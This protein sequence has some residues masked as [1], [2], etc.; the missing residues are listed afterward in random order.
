MSAQFGRWNFSGRP[1]MAG[2]IERAS[3]ML[4]S[5]GPDGESRYAGPSVDI[6]YRAFHTT[7]ES[8]Q[9]QQPVQVA[10][11]AVLTWDGRLDNREELILQFD[12][13]VTLES[14]DVAIV[15]AAYERWGTKS[16]G[17]LI[18]D[19]ALSVW[20]P[21]EQTLI[22]AKDF[23]GTRR[24]YYLHDEE[25]ILWSS[26]LEPLVLLSGKTFQLEKEYLAGWLSFFPAAHLTPYAGIHAVPPST[27]VSLRAGNQ[28]VTR[29]WEFDPHKQIR[30]ATD[31][32]YEE[33]FRAVFRQSVRRR[34]RSD[35]AILAELSGGMD[36]SSIVC[37]ADKLIDEQI[38]EMPRLDTVSYYDDSEPNWNER[39]YFTLVENQRG[40]PG[41]H[42]DMS[43]QDSRALDH[44]SE[45]FCA[46]P[47]S[48][49]SSQVTQQLAVYM[50][51]HGHRAVLSGIGGDEMTGGIPTAVPELA[52]L[53]ARGRFARLA[54]RLKAWAIHKKQPWFHLLGA[55]LRE[56]FS[57]ELGRRHGRHMPLHWLLPNYARTYRA[58]LCGYRRRLKLFGARPSFQENLQ[59]LDAVRRQLGCAASPAVLCEMRFPFLDRD[60]LEFLYAVPANQV[61]RPGQRRSLMR[62]ALSGVVPKEILNR[63]RKAFVV[64]HAIREIATDSDKIRSEFHLALLAELQIV[65]YQALVKAVDAIL[66]GDARCT[67]PVARTLLMEKWIRDLTS[68]NVLSAA[69]EPLAVTC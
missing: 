63:R 47:S 18:G 15:A 61:V 48:N 37:M 4:A 24:L 2:Y 29:Y 21:K 8:R 30:Y 39:P 35:R 59:T 40:R 67:V 36:S 3:R 69:S 50:A 64:R 68:R 20:E 13:R 12:G 43:T 57:A 9:E 56:F 44:Q 26:I 28:T 27:F 31:G 42:I 41:L 17:I 33:H 1:A 14:P 6:I 16:F 51:L 55:T 23:L 5:H 54:S 45:R 38:P 19:W 25:Q 65:S 34:L 52:D 11:D 46:V 58:A 32:E 53:L 49:H 60:L 22:L 62:R 66:R 7:S 10:W